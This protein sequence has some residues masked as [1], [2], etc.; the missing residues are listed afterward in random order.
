MVQENEIIKG[1][2]FKNKNNKEIQVFGFTV[3]NEKTCVWTREAYIYSENKIQYHQELYLLEEIQHLEINGFWLKYFGFIENQY[4]KT[5]YEL[6][7]DEY[8]FLTFDF[9]NKKLGIYINNT[10]GVR[11]W[12]DCDAV[13]KLQVLLIFLSVVNKESN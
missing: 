13:N 3:E 1:C 12:I 9:K 5:Y 10:R 2:F 6:Y 8:Y 11:Y 7:K 4:I